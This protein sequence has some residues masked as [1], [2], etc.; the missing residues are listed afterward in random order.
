MKPNEG[1]V[2]TEE[3]IAEVLDGFEEEML[4]AMRRGR[5]SADVVEFPGKQSNELSELELIRRQRVIDQTWE[6]VVAERRELERIA[7][8]SCHRGPLDS[9]SN[10]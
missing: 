4:A 9:D 7:R 6:R 8:Q 3:D 5:K 1:R 10:L 2:C